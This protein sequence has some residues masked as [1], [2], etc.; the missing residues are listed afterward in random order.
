MEKITEDFINSLCEQIISYFNVN[1]IEQKMTARPKPRKVSFIKR[2]AGQWT[3]DGILMSEEFAA[4]LE[5]IL[6]SFD[7][8]NITK[9]I[10]EKVVGQVENAIKMINRYLN[11]VKFFDLDDM[12]ARKFVNK[13]KT[14]EHDL[15]EILERLNKIGVKDKK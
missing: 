1:D 4:G 14:I 6:D 7:K 9:G 2:L 5:A 8:K 10:A 13:T 12:I 3:S 11:I 15:E